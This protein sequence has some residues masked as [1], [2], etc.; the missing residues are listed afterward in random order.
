MCTTSAAFLRATS[1]INVVHQHTKNVYRIGIELRKFSH[2]GNTTWRAKKKK[3]KKKKETIDWNHVLVGNS[4]FEL[5]TRC[6]KFQFLYFELSSSQITS[7]MHLIRC[8]KFLCFLNLR[9]Y[10]F[11]INFGQIISLNVI[12]RGRKFLFYWNWILN[13]FLVLSS[14]E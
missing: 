4:S 8:K 10:I 12:L 6:L 7:L 2:A 1:P 3:K 14:I 11:E 13:I 9:V 5:T